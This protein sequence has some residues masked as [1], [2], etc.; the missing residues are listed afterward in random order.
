MAFGYLVHNVNFLCVCVCVQISLYV[1]FNQ[2]NMCM[3]FLQG[4]Y[5]EIKHIFNNA[6]SLSFLRTIVIMRS[7]LDY[8]KIWIL[9][10]HGPDMTPV[11]ENKLNFLANLV[12]K[13]NDI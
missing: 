13:I 6:L 9:L 7:N 12:K 10:K 8:D 2:I 11:V 1:I 3:C 5:L 4:L